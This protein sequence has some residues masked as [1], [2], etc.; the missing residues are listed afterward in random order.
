M[1][2]A[3]VLGLL[4]KVIEVRL[5][6]LLAVPLQIMGSAYTPVALF[7]LG[8]QLAATR[9]AAPPGPLALAVGIRLLAAPLL[10]WLA[11]MALGVP[12]GLA[13]MLVVTASAPAGVLLAIICTEYHV[14]AKL[15][16]PTVFLSTVL[17]PIVVTGFLYAV[18]SW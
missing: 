6:P 5:P 1:I 9:F 15:A 13:D 8:A 17:S 10:T 3:V 16:P 18:R 7:A 12:R 4:L 2:P 11:V 14:G